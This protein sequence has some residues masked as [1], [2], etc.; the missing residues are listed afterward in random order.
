MINTLNEIINENKLEIKE[1]LNIIEMQQPNYSRLIKNKDILNIKN[2]IKLANNFNISLDFI[3]KEYLN[4]NKSS[5]II[6]LFNKLNEKQ[7]E[8]ILN[9]IKLFLKEN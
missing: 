4:N 1:F 8:I 5:E 9:T 2:G 3:Y 7:K 6:H